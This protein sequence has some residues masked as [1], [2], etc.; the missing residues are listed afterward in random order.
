MLALG[1]KNFR[2]GFKKIIMKKYKI[3]FT[4]DYSEY[5]KQTQKPDYTGSYYLDSIKANPKELER[6]RKW[7]GKEIT[8]L[9]LETL[10]E[11]FGQVVFNGETIEIY[12]DYRE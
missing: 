11:E 7:S 9:E 8:I 1:F 3:E 10:I 12:N 6:C 5:E 2:E 4:K